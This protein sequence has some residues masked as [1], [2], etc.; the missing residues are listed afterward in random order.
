MKNCLPCE[1]HTPT[2]TQGRVGHFHRDVDATRWRFAPSGNTSGFP[3]F[4]WEG[5]R[6]EGTPPSYPTALLLFIAPR[7][8]A[9]EVGAIL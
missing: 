9:G 6:S 3:S 8:A 5:V 2:F 1:L 4:L 7:Q